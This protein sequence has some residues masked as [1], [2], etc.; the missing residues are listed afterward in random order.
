LLAIGS[1]LFPLLEVESTR[2]AFE[3]DGN[4]QNSPLDARDE[5]AADALAA[6]ISRINEDIRRNHKD[7]SEAIAAIAKEIGALRPRVPQVI[8]TVVI[9]PLLLAIIASIFNPIADIYIRR[10]L[11]DGSK[12]RVSV[13]NALLKEAR[14]SPDDLKT[15]RIVVLDHVKVRA[16]RKK[17]S[18]VVATLQAGDVVVLISK[19]GPRALVGFADPKRGYSGYGWLLS[20][21]LKECQLPYSRP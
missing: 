17:R 20:K 2:Q 10:R 14:S 8:L 13:T 11:T 6:S 1:Q 3:P 15:L 7:A 19:R 4:E 5:S 18:A 16:S 9:L 12:A 21:H